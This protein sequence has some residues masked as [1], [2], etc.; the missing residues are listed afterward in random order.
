MNFSQEIQ[1]IKDIALAMGF[2]AV[3]F[4]ALVKNSPASLRFEEWLTQGFAGEMKYLERGLEKRKNPQLILPEAKSCIALSWDYSKHNFGDPAL[5]P[6]PYISRYAWRKD[7]HE[8]LGD[9]LSKL[10]VKL[11]EIFPQEHFKSY[12]DTGPVMEKE[13]AAQAGLGW[14]GKHTNLIDE[15]KGSYFFL[16]SL[17]TTLDLEPH[18]PVKDRCGTCTRCIKVCPTRAIIAPYVLDARLCISYLT[19]EN[20]GPIPLELRRGIGQHVF[21]CDD[22]QEV[23]PWNRDAKL[24]EEFLRNPSLD[25]LHRYLE[26]DETEFKAYFK[27]SPI[28]RSKRRGF[29]RNVCVVLGNLGK[30]ESIPFL[31]RVLGDLEPLIREHAAWALEE[32]K[33]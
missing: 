2:S 27:D 4:S 21:G 30:A 1:M 25:E 6:S 8:I 23:C 14:V 15:K 10:E 32:I 26:M 22:C 9:K 13:V 31:N 29:L 20:K 19:I 3:G 18:Q 33:G 7:Y 16:A 17:L 28:L 12:V 5:N 11:K 24:P